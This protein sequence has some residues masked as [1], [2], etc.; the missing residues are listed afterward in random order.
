MSCFAV[1]MDSPDERADSTAPA[2]ELDRYSDLDGID[3]AVVEEFFDTDNGS[4]SLSAT[5]DWIRNNSS[6][7]DN[8]GRSPTRTYFDPND[9]SGEYPSQKDRAYE[10][11]RS[12]RTLANWQDGMRSDIS[13]GSQN[14]WAD[15]QRWVETFATRLHG[16]S[17]HIDQTKQV[18]KTIDM[19]PYQSAGITTEVLIVG[20]LSLY[21]DSDV[22]DFDNRTLARDG[23]KELLDALDSGVGEYETVRSK[24]RKNDKELLFP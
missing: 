11:K 7:E 21:I 23:A 1:A 5:E 14:W 16:K 3:P 2:D 22:T 9:V 20:I 8:D 18:L 4:G 24:I 6:P 17:H 12:W 15:K 10:D 19:T 13:R